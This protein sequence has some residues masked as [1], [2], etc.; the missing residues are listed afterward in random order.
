[1]NPA[2]DPRPHP[3]PMPAPEVTEAAWVEVDPGAPGIAS[4]VTGEQTPAPVPPPAAQPVPPSP[5][6]RE[7][8]G[9]YGVATE[10]VD[11]KNNPTVVGAPTLIAVLRALDV[12]AGSPAAIAS[13]LAE[14]R[15]R[16]WRRLLPPTVITTD[17]AA[18][19]FEVHV[20][21]GA[22]VD[23][24][25]EFETGGGAAVAQIDNWAED[26]EIDGHRIGEASFRLPEGMPTGYHTLRATCGEQTA[27]APLIVTPQWLGIPEKLGRRRFWGL[28]TQL[29]SVRS[30]GSW[31]V[32]DLSDLAQL[33]VWSAARHG[34]DYVLVNPLCAAEPGLP[35]EPSP[36]Y[37]TSRRFFNPLYLRVEDIAEYAYL[38]PDSLIRVR[39]LRADLEEKV[40]GRDVIDRDSVWYAKR[41][42]LE[43]VY[44]A[45]LTPGRRIA[46]DAFCAR[47]GP[48]LS[49]F[50]TWSALTERY[51]RDW[52]E[53]PDEYRAVGGAAVTRFRAEHPEEIEFFCWLQ[54]CLD[55]QLRSAQ[56]AALDAGMGL[57]IVHDLPV[58]VNPAGADAWALDD[59]FAAGIGVGAPPDQYSQLGQDWGQPPLRPDRLA[60]T[61]YAV[62]RDMFRSILRH[63]GGLRVDH[64]IGLFRLWWV[65]RGMAATHG[66]YVTYD[67]TALIGIL[68]LE[69]QRAGALVVGEDLGT[70]QPWVRDYLAGRG[71]LGTSI[72]WFE[73]D[74]HG[75]PLP[76][77][78]WR[79]Y[80]LASVTTHDLPPT[81]G[82]LAGAH[83]RLRHRLG[84][85][86]EPLDQELDRARAER[87]LWIDQL[88]RAGLLG[89]DPGPDAVVRALHD[90][91]TT[92]D[93]RML[94]IALP[95]A[96]GDLRTQNQPGTSWQYPNWRVPLAGPDQRPMALEQVFTDDRAAALLDRVKT[97][98]QG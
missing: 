3:E 57:G 20:P 13:A 79:E 55:E 92:T 44:A 14:V 26:R 43:I 9:H 39:A 21:A 51:G 87:Q 36:Y 11:W 35:V 23:V 86:T 28:N 83:V 49:D 25:V 40:G 5:E 7:L 38:H 12:E 58:G 91:L 33:A 68:A 24:R 27:T 78:R 63:S 75:D 73:A 6:L 95:D 61:G 53:W 47:Q 70:V 98:L 45:G 62:Y 67:H 31:G 54:W 74:E 4:V 30:G 52:R 15:I 69:A 66:T 17:T 32:G 72:L 50:A 84:M 97:R 8:A 85:L 88:V 19:T 80:C 96:V 64:I 93:A 41:Q 71:I 89:T 16:A 82:Y 42:A 48:G 77:E 37:P 56:A 2:P 65:P 81:A 60:E 18:V 29:Y 10:F 76:A 59:Q 46:F 94:G 90:F 34:A 1:M 22:A